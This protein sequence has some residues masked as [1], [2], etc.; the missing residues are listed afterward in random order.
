MLR[1][2]VP[3]PPPSPD[4]GGREGVC[5]WRRRGRKGNPHPALPRPTAGGGFKG[6]FLALLLLAAPAFAIGVDEPL[7]DPAQ[8]VRAREIAKSLRCLVCQNQSI[9]DSNAPLAK[10][11]RRI[12]R[13]RIEAGDSDA[14]VQDYL[15]A[16]YG[17]WVL[18]KPPFNART[19]AL[20]I[21]PFALL[22]LAG[23]GVAIYY[24]RLA[25]TAKMAAPAPLTAEERARL[26]RLI[27]GS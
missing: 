17:D 19:A 11:L 23:I 27:S 16:R 18:M 3:S 2:L 25:A 5:R 13:E 4:G 22:A 15:V 1:W 20:W 7:P 6:A 26:D 12:V 21:G 14:Q 10:D 8:E 9:E 24:R